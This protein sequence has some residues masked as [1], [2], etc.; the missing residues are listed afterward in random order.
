LLTE[1][2]I[3]RAA[4]I[5]VHDPSLAAKQDRASPLEA[6]KMTAEFQRAV[7]LVFI[8]AGAAITGC[9]GDTVFACFGSS[10]ERVYLER[11]K[12]ETQYGDDPKAHSNHHPAAKAIGFITELLNQ[13]NE[14]NFAQ[15]KKA[16]TDTSS[17]AAWRFGIDCGDC[18]FSW[19]KESGYT[20]NGRPVVRA[21]ILAA[22]T[23][24]Y[25]AQV[26]I[27]DAVREKIVQPVRKLN[28]LGKNGE[29]GEYFYEL[30][31]G[32]A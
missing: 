12:N 11:T 22:L 23:S 24:R 18:A 17:C 10:L 1:I 7:S 3:A 30:P 19:S 29:A 15:S 27:T 13:K 21:R 5:A 16:V 26:L 28:A 32:S 14:N 20:A 4:I 8:R 31:V 25:Q 9:E 2:N 6:A